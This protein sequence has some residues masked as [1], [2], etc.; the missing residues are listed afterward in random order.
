[1]AKQRK[2]KAIE[3]VSWPPWD[4]EPPDVREGKLTVLEREIAKL[5]QLKAKSKPKAR[6]TPRQPGRRT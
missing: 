1:M 6:M 3:D 5:D 2:A 4:W